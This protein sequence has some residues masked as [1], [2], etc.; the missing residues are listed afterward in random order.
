MGDDGSG[1]FFGTL[2]GFCSLCTGDP[3]V[4]I[5]ALL[6]C[7]FGIVPPMAFVTSNPSGAP[8]KS[9]FKGS[10]CVG[11]VQSKV[12][13]GAVAPC[14]WLVIVRSAK[15]LPVVSDSLQLCDLLKQEYSIMNHTMIFD[16]I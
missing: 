11:F 10:C 3:W 14:C 9:D 8:L 5:P 7:C 12:V 13:L 16:E 2:L 6:V 1:A 4:D 15:V